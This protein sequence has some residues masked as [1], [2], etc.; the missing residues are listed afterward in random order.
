[1]SP[2]FPPCLSVSPV[3]SAFDFPRLTPQFIPDAAKHNGRYFQRTAL[4][5]SRLCFDA[6]VLGALVR[7]KLLG[8]LHLEIACHFVDCLTDRW[9]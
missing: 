3:V 4:H 1:M 6:R 8:E 5:G 9:A 7:P 2:R